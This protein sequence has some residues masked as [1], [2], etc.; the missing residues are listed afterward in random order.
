[1][2]DNSLA[3]DG[4]LSL[5]DAMSPIP[6]ACMGEMV[7]SLC[8]ILLDGQLR[9]TDREVAAQDVDGSDVIDGCRETFADL[10]DF[11]ANRAG[12]FR[13]VSLI[14]KPACDLISA[15]AG[16]GSQ[17]IAYRYA[18]AA[19]DPFVLLGADYQALNEDGALD[20]HDPET[21]RGTPLSWFAQRARLLVVTANQNLREKCRCSGAAGITVE[22]LR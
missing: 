1:M 19:L 14:D 17:A 11:V 22:A 3:L 20:L 12:R 7:D 16:A 15:A 18:L 6:E 4:A 13:F 2:L 5:L 8:A 9:T 21:R 10:A